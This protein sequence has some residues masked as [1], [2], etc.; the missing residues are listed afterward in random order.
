MGV[1][2]LIGTSA[3]FSRPEKQRKIDVHQVGN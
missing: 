1:L 2:P 3:T